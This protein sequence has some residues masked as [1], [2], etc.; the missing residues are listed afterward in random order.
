MKTKCFICNDGTIAL[1]V[2]TLCVIV[3]EARKLGFFAYAKVP[4][5]N[6][7]EGSRWSV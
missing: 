7:S 1:I 3:C 5:P 4:T 6:A 2:V